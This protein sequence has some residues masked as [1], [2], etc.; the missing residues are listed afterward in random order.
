MIHV[1]LYFNICILIFNY[2][3]N[4]IQ[5]HIIKNRVNYINGISIFPFFIFGFSTLFLL[6]QVLKF[7]F[8]CFVLMSQLYFYS[9]K[10]L[11]F[12]FCSSTS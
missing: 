5:N 4:D 3:I 9:I 2:Y 10:Y 12:N 8:F 7:F 1:Y 11:D 6:N